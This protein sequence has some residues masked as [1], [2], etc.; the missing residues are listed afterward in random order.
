MRR[1]AS[2]AAWTSKMKKAPSHKE[3][4][5]VFLAMGA[6]GGVNNETLGVLESALQNKDPEERKKAESA[7]KQFETALK[8][9]KKTEDGDDYKAAAAKAK[10]LVG[11]LGKTSALETSWGPTIKVAG[12]SNKP[13]A[14]LDERS[15]TVW[16]TFYNFGTVND[17]TKNIAKWERLLN[18]SRKHVFEAFTGILEDEGIQF[19]DFGEI[20]ID[21]LKAHRIAVMS[22]TIQA[23]GKWDTE[24]QGDIASEALDKYV[25]G[26]KPMP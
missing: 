23:M 19:R 6:A 2:D 25:A 11:R 16:V 3:R 20:Y 5:Q 8:K 17:V 10:A 26:F 22:F 14:W 24:Q 1:T 15:L 13:Y 9:M 12:P 4:L 18:L 21:D 7:F